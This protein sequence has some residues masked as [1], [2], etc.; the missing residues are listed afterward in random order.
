MQD[1][2]L[3]DGAFTEIA[4]RLNAL[5]KFM[6]DTN[7]SDVLTWLATL[8]LYF[9]GGNVGIGTNPTI[10]KLHVALIADTTVAYFDNIKNNGGSS[11]VV[12]I[13]DERGYAGVNSGNSLAVR[14]WNTGDDTGNLLY[15]AWFDGADHPVLVAKMSGNVGIG[16]TTVP[17]KLTVAGLINMKNYTVATLPA[18]T[19]GDICYVTDA[20]A[21]AFLAI[22]VGGG[23]VKSPVFHNGTNWVG[24]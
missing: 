12:K 10:G 8:N 5:E 7:S 2:F 24:F 23:T 4:R 11:D 15:L 1:D 14:A 22:I 16:T 21:P 17:S 13:Y 18:G 19:Q 6:R 3:R 20:L 9:S